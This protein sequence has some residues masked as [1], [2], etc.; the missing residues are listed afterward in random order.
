MKPSVYNG[1]GKWELIYR[2]C[3]YYMNNAFIFLSQA[4][5]LTNS[6]LTNMNSLNSLSLSSGSRTAPMQTGTLSS[7]FSSTP[8]MAGM[9]TLAPISNG[10]NSPMGFQTAGMGMQTTAP[11]VYGGMAS[12][13]STPNFN[14]LSQNQNQSSKPAD[15]SALDS[16][17]SANKPKVSLNQMV[18]KPATGAAPS[19]W[20]NQ[21]GAGQPSQTAPMQALPMGMTG[22][23]GGFGM[24]ANPFFSPQNFSQPAAAP[25]M[26][27]GML[28]QSMS[29]NNDLK[30]LFG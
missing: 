6:L 11:G 8:T 23:Q 9:G 21:L 3:I 17:F 7:G 27:T 18:P 14:A 30:D 25:T 2:P 13:N 12:T 29:V 15:M 10:F 26:N 16:L 20:I 5:D 4:K 22:V 1:Y 28:K 19:P 24:Q